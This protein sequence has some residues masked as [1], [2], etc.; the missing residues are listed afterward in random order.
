MARVISKRKASALHS[1]QL[2][3]QWHYQD[4]SLTAH[5]ISRDGAIVFFRVFGGTTHSWSEGALR[6][7]NAVETRISQP[8]TQ[9]HGHASPSLAYLI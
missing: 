9:L 3:A 2:S 6:L 8:P 7:M 4:V 5:T 1:K